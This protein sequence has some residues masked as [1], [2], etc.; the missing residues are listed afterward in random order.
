MLRNHI[1][2][3]SNTTKLNIRLVLKAGS[4]KIYITSFKYEPSWL[5]K[6]YDTGTAGI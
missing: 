5:W 2:P 6:L 3:D 4:G 1:Q